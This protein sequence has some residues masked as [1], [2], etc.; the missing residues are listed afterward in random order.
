MSRKLIEAGSMKKGTYWI[1]NDEPCRVVDT[2]HSKSGKHG[3][4]KNRIVSIG[5]FTGKKYDTVHPAN[6]RVE[7]PAIDK[8][9]AQVLTITGDSVMAMDLENHET[10]EFAIPEDEDIK[11]QIKDGVTIEFWRVMDRVI[12]QRVK[13]DKS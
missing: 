10:F 6:D 4:A 2:T 9:N 7:S 13:G 11:K 3:H 12:V 8:R 1:N 5:L